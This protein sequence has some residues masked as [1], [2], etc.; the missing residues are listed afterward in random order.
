MKGGGGNKTKLGEPDHI[1]PA[2]HYEDAR[3]TLKAIGKKRRTML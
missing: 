2:G 3:F 1:G